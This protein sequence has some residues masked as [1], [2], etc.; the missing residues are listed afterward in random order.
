VSS[1]HNDEDPGLREN[2]PGAP[3]PGAIQHDRLAY[4]VADLTGAHYR[5]FVNSAFCALL[6][7]VPSGAEVET[8]LARLA[9]GVSKVE[10]L[11]DL[12]RSPEGRR[13][14]SRIDGLAFRYLLVKA[15]RVPLLGYVLDGCR[16]LVALPLHARHQRATEAWVAARDESNARALDRLS[17]RLDALDA[18]AKAFTEQD[19][20]LGRH[21]DAVRSFAQEIPHE[22][23]RARDA[24]ERRLADAELRLHGGIHA[25]EGR[26]A[27]HDGRVEE[28]EFIRQRFYA[29]NHWS[30]S[31]GQAFAQIEQVADARRQQHA[32]FAT[33]V[34]HATLAADH[35]RN[36]RN[37]AWADVL[38]QR[39]PPHGTVLAFASGVDWFDALGARGL[40]ALGAEPDAALADD[41]HVDGLEVV[42]AR[43]FL[44]DCE[45]ACADGIGVLAFP[46][47]TRSLPVADFLDEAAR[48]LRPGGS[49]LLG[50][51]QEP[52]TLVDALRGEAVPAVA[53]ELLRHAMAAAG[54]ID[55]VHADAADGTIAL[56]AR[57]GPARTGGPIP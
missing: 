24:L 40:R 51:A 1:E 47:L 17:A 6:K 38:A 25:L 29:I 41:V 49:L 8:Q 23:A 46:S 52:V 9:A 30:H 13:V 2:P 26:I 42:T 19:A 34:A 10:I 53:P 14:G 3:A 7:R 37:A 48:V 11:G 31:L 45:D 15:A 43:Q 22:I 20:L 12:Q 21:I 55:V 18:Q 16:N 54:F 57:L 5:S 36:G 4:T 44:R 33:Q 32:G 28:F 35:G 56:L 39:L 50:F 27:A